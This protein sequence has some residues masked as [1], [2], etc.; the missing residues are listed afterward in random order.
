VHGLKEAVAVAEAAV[1][2]PTEVSARL[3]TAPTVTG[4]IPALGE[5]PFGSIK[6]SR[7]GED[8][9]SL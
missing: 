3:T 6:H 5:N 7:R 1:K 4:I 9:A 2:I 8:T